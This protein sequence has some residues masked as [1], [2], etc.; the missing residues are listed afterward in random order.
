MDGHPHKKFQQELLTKMKNLG[1]KY[2][3]DYDF[4]PWDAEFAIYIGDNDLI[5]SELTK[6]ELED[7][8]NHYNEEIKREPNIKTPLLKRKNEEITDPNDRNIGM[9]ITDAD[10]CA[11]LRDVKNVDAD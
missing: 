1:Q 10:F 8:R 2:I 5:I 7:L 11:W 3:E 6:E 4:S 9:K